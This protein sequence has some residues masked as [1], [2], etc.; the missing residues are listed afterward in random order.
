MSLVGPRPEMANLIEEFRQRIPHYYLRYK[1]KA[2]LTGWAQVH[3]LRGNTSLQ[4]RIEYDLFYIEHWS[5]WLDMKILALTLVRG[6]R[7]AY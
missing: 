2:G 7:N 1:V 6:W 3:G 5:L 4:Q